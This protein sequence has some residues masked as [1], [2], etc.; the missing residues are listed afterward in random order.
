VKNLPEGA[1]V[2]LGG[3]ISRIKKTVTKTGRSAGQPMCIITLEDLDGQIEA[4]I[5]SE[6]LA[7]ITRKNP[8]SVAAEEIV[9]LRGKVDKRR[10]TPGI[11]VNDLFPISDAMPR[12]TRWVKVQIDQIDGAA[13]LLKDLKPILTKHTGNCQTVLNVPPPARSAQPL[14]STAPGPSAPPPR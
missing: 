10:E 1:E 13:Q 11:L 8:K 4:T 2:T 3:M 12:L 6:T 9:F 14:T 7:E 5:F